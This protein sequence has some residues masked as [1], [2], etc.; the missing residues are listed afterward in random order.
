[1][2]GHHP[3][4]IHW[5]DVEAQAV[6]AGELRGRWRDLGGAA[7]SFRTGVMLAEIAPGA[8]SAP[9]HVHADEEEL[10]YVLDGDGLSWQDGR[11]YAIGAGDCVVH[12][13]HEEAHALVA[14][15]TGLTVL[16]FGPR[17]E[18]NITWLPHARVMRVGPR[19]VP[20]DV[21]SPYAA[22]A[23]AGPLPLPAAPEA[24]RPATIAAVADVP[25]IEIHRGDKR[26]KVRNLGAFLGAETTGARHTRIAPGAH[27]NPHHCHGAGE[28]LLVVLGGAG[29]LRLG[30]ER[31]DVARGAVLAR[32]PGTGVA[33]SFVAGEQGLEILAWG[34]RVP[35]EIA[36][37]PDSGKLFL[38]GVGVV[39]RL[40]PCS[41]WDGEE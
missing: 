1:M 10:Y 19:W 30:E 28:E 40:E 2:S 15:P 37:Y 12:R 3:N 16:A 22:E 21:V 5:D 38:A 18:S 9:A 29:R 6:E 25:A 32:P 23:A 20:V 39:G 24:R 41:F 36:Y 31:F 27:G 13:V 26:Y 11:T 17:A 34:T 33:H 4:L 8:R 7:G 14:G 35:N